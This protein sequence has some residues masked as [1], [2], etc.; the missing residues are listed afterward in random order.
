MWSVRVPHCYSLELG[1]VQARV[2]GRSNASA[3][4]AMQC[5]N[6]KGDWN[7]NSNI[8]HVP[9]YNYTFISLATSLHG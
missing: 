2:E 4:R 9:L 3:P 6:G 1:N 7:V 8:Q 5:H